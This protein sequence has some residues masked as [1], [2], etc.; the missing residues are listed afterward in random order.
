MTTTM[1]L[2]VVSLES[3]RGAE[4][5]KLLERK[6][7]VPIQAPSMREVPLSDQA[8]ALAF[9]ERLMAGECDV[10][11]LLTG[12]GTRALVGVL[13]TRWERAAVLEALGGVQ[14]ACRGPKP[15]AA[16]KTLGL[17]P[18]VVAPEPNTYR[19]LL[20][21]MGALDLDR[22]RVYVQEYG[23]SNEELLAA[24]RGRASEVHVVRVYAWDLPQDTAPLERAIAALCDGDADAVLFTSARQVDHLLEVAD[25][26]GRREALVEALQRERLVASIGPVTS[27]ALAAAGFPADLEPAHPKMGH[28]AKAL[29]ED[30]L[31]AFE[32][33]RG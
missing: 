2:R 5:A 9:G 29:V 4:M 11:V 7:L 20:E 28:L 32:R 30:G 19:E 13:E 1:A 14:L 22:A 33:K 21:A 24:L 23:R 26:M 25:R 16:L 3:R 17:E 18:A 8:E 12:V 15:R 31:R 6:G 10:L 27:E